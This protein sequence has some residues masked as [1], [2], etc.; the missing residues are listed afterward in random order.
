MEFGWPRLLVSTGIYF[1][2]QKSA[3]ITPTNESPQ[4]LKTHS[5]WYRTRREGIGTK[6]GGRGRGP[7]TS[8]GSTFPEILPNALAAYLN[9]SAPITISADGILKN[10]CKFKRHSLNKVR[11][12]SFVARM[13]SCDNV[14]DCSNL[15]I[16]LPRDSI[17]CLVRHERGNI[18]VSG[19][20]VIW[21]YWDERFESVVDGRRSTLF[22]TRTV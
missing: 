22:R 21:E 1:P 20:P 18:W 16:P 9:S 6:A 3:N 2:M 4:S 11:C 17:P 10:V 14:I 15:D 13:F 19:R 8:A 12:R 7:K 5:I